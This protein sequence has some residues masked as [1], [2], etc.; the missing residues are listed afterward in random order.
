MAIFSVHYM[1]MTKELYKTFNIVYKREYQDPE[2]GS[3][4]FWSSSTLYR[5]VP[6][7]KIKYYRKRLLMFKDYMDK[8]FKEDA[9]NF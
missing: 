3:D 6:V 2:D 5:N 7:S 8:I 1:Y 4:T 9:T